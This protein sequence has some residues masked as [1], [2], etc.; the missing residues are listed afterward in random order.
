M[1]ATDAR[2][3]YSDSHAQ[4]LYCARRVGRNEARSERR[5]AAAGAQRTDLEHEAD[6]A[7][8]ERDDR[9]VVR[10]QLVRVCDRSFPRLRCLRVPW[11]VAERRERAAPHACWLDYFNQRNKGHKHGPDTVRVWARGS[12]GESQR[13]RVW[14]ARAGGGAAT[15]GG[16][17]AVARRSGRPPLR[18]R[19]DPSPEEPLLAGSPTGPSGPSQ[20]AVL[21]AGR[22]GDPV[23]AL[24]LRCEQVCKVCVWGGQRRRLGEWWWS[25][26]GRGLWRGQVDVMIECVTRWPGQLWLLLQSMSFCHCPSGLEGA[27]YSPCPACP[28]AAPPVHPRYWRFNLARPLMLSR[29]RRV[30]RR[31]PVPIGEPGFA[32]FPCR[33]T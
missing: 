11:V 27:D 25:C 24:Q 32:L 19:T 21:A 33:R 2:Q 10:R 28:P 29:A 13:S 1:L 20:R 7:A 30:G 3:Q 22:R 15:R 8:E 5:G 9:K 16:D 12:V 23:A 6:H 31:E 17:I 26:G 14:R 18:V 4:I